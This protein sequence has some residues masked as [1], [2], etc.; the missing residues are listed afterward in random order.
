[1]GIS[2]RRGWDKLSSGWDKLSSHPEMN[3]AND[4]D[5][6]G[7]IIC[8]CDAK[9]TYKVHLPFGMNELPFRIEG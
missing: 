3:I 4:P 7:I 1:M 6:R 2:Y 5:G 8:C 9:G